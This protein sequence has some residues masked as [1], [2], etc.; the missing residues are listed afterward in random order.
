MPLITRKKA[1]EMLAKEAEK[2]TPADLADIYNN[3]YPQEKITFDEA[4]RD[5][6]AV[7]TKVLEYIKRG[8]E[9]EDIVD[10]WSVIFP[11]HRRR[12]FDEE[13]NRFHYDETPER[14]PVD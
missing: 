4:E 6:P 10:L 12:W 9:V 11:A 13:K 3:I 5:H 2:A 14:Y 7:L 8:L 1:G